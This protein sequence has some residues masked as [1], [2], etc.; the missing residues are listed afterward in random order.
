VPFTGS[1]PAAVLPFLRSALPPSALVIG[2]MAPDFPYYFP[3][4]PRW[5][6]HTARGVL[7]VDLLLGAAGWALWHGLLAEPALEAAP[8]PVRGRLRGRVR[9]GLAARA[10]DPAAVG[11]ALLG[12]AIGSATHVLWDEFTHEG[13]RSVERIPAL[14]GTWLGRPGW[15]WAQDAGGVVGAAA[16][17]RWTAQWWRRT[18]AAP[19][20]PGTPWAWAVVG[21]AGLVGAGRGA[22]GQSVRRRALEAGAFRGGASATAAAVVLAVGHRVQHATDP[23][24]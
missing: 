18:P 9:T 14:R 8:A 24:R 20:A 5:R 2:S 17:F 10:G 13:R 1:H 12:L 3:R 21:L 15:T 6:T 16:L 7:G 19:A 22:A 11:R 4:S 23:A